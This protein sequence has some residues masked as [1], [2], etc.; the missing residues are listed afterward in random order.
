MKKK[1]KV[2]LSLLLISCFTGICFAWDDELAGTTEI[3]GYY[4]QYRDFSLKTGVSEYDFAPARLSGGGFSVAQNIAEWFSIWTQLSVFG[5][6]NQMVGSNQYQ[7]SVRIINNLEGIRYQTQQYGP[8]R[9]Y[10]KVGAGITWYGFDY[11][12]ES[13]SG[14]RFG[15]GYGGGMNIWLNRNI[16]ITLDVSNIGMNLPNFDF[17]DVEGRKSWDFGMTY[18]PGITFR[19]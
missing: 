5:T 4:Q 15:F 18:T 13:I 17:P 10:G 16:G 14:T 2:M 6:V 7:K 19:F 9:F 3:T 11:F 8:F 1:F 12:G